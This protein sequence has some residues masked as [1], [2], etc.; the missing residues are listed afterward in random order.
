MR[1]SRPEKG[2]KAPRNGSQSNF[3]RRARALSS[4]ALVVAVEL[5]LNIIN[6][7]FIPFVH[8]M[9]SASAVDSLSTGGVNLGASRFLRN[10]LAAIKGLET[11]A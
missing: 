7:P 11:N 5:R 1:V 8:S 10:C 2:E 3:H 6:I 4:M 9:R